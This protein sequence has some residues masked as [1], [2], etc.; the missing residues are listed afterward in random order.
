MKKTA[1]RKLV[2]TSIAC[3]F[4]IFIALG[5]IPLNAQQNTTGL[6]QD[7][8]RELWEQRQFEVEDLYMQGELEE[9]LRLAA[10]ASGL[11]VKAYGATDPNTFNSRLTE[12][13][14]MAEMG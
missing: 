2:K 7:E 6:S 11:S 14:L 3:F 1:I 5:N 9:A 4:V 10:E 12:A 8:A 13:L